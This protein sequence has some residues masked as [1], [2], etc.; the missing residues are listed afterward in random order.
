MA[1]ANVLITIPLNTHS[2]DST[3]GKIDNWSRRDIYIDRFDNIPKKKK[4]IRTTEN[5]LYYRK[6]TKFLLAGWFGRIGLLDLLILRIVIAAGILRIR[7][8][9]EPRFL[10]QLSYSQGLDAILFSYQRDSILIGH[11]IGKVVQFVDIGISVSLRERVGEERGLLA[12]GR[13]RFDVA[14]GRV[15]CLQHSLCSQQFNSLIVSISAP[16]IFI[17]IF[18]YGMI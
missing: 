18:L 5:R 12:D 10:S 8:L 14:S 11:Q 6:R 16:S 9:F 3:D 1:L 17:N 13:E 4:W 7:Q 15:V 2:S